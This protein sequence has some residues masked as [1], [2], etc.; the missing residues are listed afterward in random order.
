VEVRNVVLPLNTTQEEVLRAIEALNSD[1]SVHGVLIFRPLPKHIGDAAVCGA[2][3]P[4]K[5]MDGITDGSAAAVFKGAGTGFAPCTAQAS[6]EILDHYGI[7]P[8]G[9]RAVVVGRSLV[10]GRPVAM[11]LMQRNAT[12]TICHTKTADMPS[13]T[14]QAEILVVAAG[15]AGAVGANYVSGGQTII[16]VG[17]NVNAEGKL[18]GDVDFAAAEPVVAG[19]TPVPGGVGAVTTAV[20]ASHVV[21]AARIFAQNRK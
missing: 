2:L 15:K 20:L 10:I 17:V 8:T 18:C 4:S 19:I 6:M 16:D 1:D 21:K 12:V 7:D 14:K 11:M 13:V 9:K 5:D 3:N